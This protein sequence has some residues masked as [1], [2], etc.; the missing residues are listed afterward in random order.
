MKN[1]IPFEFKKPTTPAQAPNAPSCYD[2]LRDSELTTLLRTSYKKKDFLH[3]ASGE[4]VSNIYSR[5]Y[6]V[7]IEGD[8]FHAELHFEG[9]AYKANWLFKDEERNILLPMFPTEFTSLVRKASLVDPSYVSGTW[10]FRSRGGVYGIELI[11][12]D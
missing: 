12:A 5:N 3:L 7:V 9:P 8:P 11:T 4:V 10:G 1:P 2:E 6:T